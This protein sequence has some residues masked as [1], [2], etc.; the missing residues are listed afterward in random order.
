MTVVVFDDF[1]VSHLSSVLS[2]ARQAASLFEHFLQKVRL[3]GAL[4]SLHFVTPQ[5][6]NNGRLEY[7]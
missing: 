6:V 3:R 1:R 7:A 2:C 5:R 4:V